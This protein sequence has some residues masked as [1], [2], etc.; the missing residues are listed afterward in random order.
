MLNF[1]QFLHERAID[2]EPN[3]SEVEDDILTI[4]KTHCSES[5]WML[6]NNTPFYRGDK[7]VRFKN[8]DAFTV[9]T[10]A[11]LRKS[12]NTSNYYTVLLD[13]NPV[14]KDYPK[15][16]R[17][18]ICST[19]AVTAG[20]FDD[21]NYFVVVPFNDAKIGYVGREDF[22]DLSIDFFGKSRRISSINGYFRELKLSDVSWDS[23]VE[24]DKKLKNDDE[25]A[26]ENFSFF[27]KELK[28]YDA[29][30]YRYSFLEEI[31]RAYDYRKIGPEHFTP[32]N[33]E[34]DGTPSEVWIGGKILMIAPSVWNQMREDLN[35]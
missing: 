14:N 8:A 29:E 13:N 12:Q 21:Y 22:W 5:M 31:K 10:S 20:Y 26:F 9:D 18:F 16:S 30:S 6:K 7:G 15:R 23:F 25:E 24:F 17:S 4:M 2:S 19:S 32:E 28:I 11:T 34:Y 33:Y 27:L 3:Y 35:A 1:K